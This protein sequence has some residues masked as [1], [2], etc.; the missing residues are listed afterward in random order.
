V[1]KNDFLADL[2]PTVFPAADRRWLK[3]SRGGRIRTDDILLPK[4]ERAFSR[5]NGM[6]LCSARQADLGHSHPLST[7]IGLYQRMATRMASAMRT[8]RRPSARAR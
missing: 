6:A 8:N 3:V 7:F 5:N 1:P 2:F 4:L